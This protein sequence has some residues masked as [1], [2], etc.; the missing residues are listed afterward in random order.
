MEEGLFPSF[1]LINLEE[2]A[3][4]DSFFFNM[5]S[6]QVFFKLLEEKKAPESNS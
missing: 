2:M 1:S 6:F 5:P 3:N 4:D